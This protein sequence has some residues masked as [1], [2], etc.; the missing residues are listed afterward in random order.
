LASGWWR[1]P[2][3]SPGDRMIT[4]DLNATFGYPRE[5]W[6]AAKKEG[7]AILILRARGGVMIQYGEFAAELHRISFDPHGTEFRNFLGQ[8]SFEE[9]AAGRGMITAIVVHKSDGHPGRGFFA[10]ARELGRNV[11]D[12]EKC[13]AEEVARVFADWQPQA[14]AG[15]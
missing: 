1:H 15:D 12:P 2:S 9:D 3:K 4:S 13:W 6:D 11:D 7:L 10:L 5:L 8:L 14:R